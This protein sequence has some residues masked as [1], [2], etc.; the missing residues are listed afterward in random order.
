MRSLF[1]LTLF[2]L[3]SGRYML[4]L[5]QTRS[6]FII[7]ALSGATAF[8]EQ[9]QYGERLEG[10]K[11]PHEIKHFDF[12]SQNQNLSMG[13]MDVSPQVKSNG[14]TVVLLHG[15]NF[16]GATWERSITELSEQGY[17]VIAPDQIGFCSSSKPRG[18]QFSFN[19]LAF[20]TQ[21]LLKSLKIEQPIFIGHSMGGML[22]TRYALNYP[23][24]VKQLILVNPI[25]LEDWQEKGVPYATLD[26]LYKNELKTTFESIK[27]YQLKF[28]YNQQW[29]PEYD[30]WVEMQAGLYTGSAKEIVAWNQAQ[31]ADMLF[32][33]PVLYGFKNL[34]VP[35]TLMIGMK[36]RTAP[37]S[38]RATAEIAKELGDYPNLSKEAVQK[39]PQATLVPFDQLGH[40]PQ[41]ESPVEFHKA[42]FKVLA[43]P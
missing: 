7:T 1:N 23:N 28:Y 40:S 37:G 6:L 4:K 19:Q 33:E 25:G 17:R 31:T 22:A 18:Y 30:Q 26:A 13:Y 2:W 39:I 12:N 41:I 38:A 35:T 5:N 34:K 29:K 11:Y 9:P 42:L 32:N 8:A 20:N 27:N 3:F 15:K 21:Q 10:F 14:K 36:D 43:Q 16:C 24:A